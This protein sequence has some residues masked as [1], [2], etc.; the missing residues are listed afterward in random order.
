[1]TAPGRPRLAAFGVDYLLILLYMGLLAASSFIVAP[2][3]AHLDTPW[4]TQ[5]LGFMT[6][7]LPVTLYFAVSEGVVGATLGKRVF[8]LV[9]TD[10]SGAPLPLE[11]SLARSAVK[12]VPW[13][14]GHTA[15]HRLVF[16]TAEGEPLPSW[17]VGFLGI[18]YAL[19]LLLAAWFTFSLF[20]GE[21]RTFYDRI[22]GSR[23]QTRVSSRRFA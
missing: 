6:L 16:W 19:S 17:Q 1:V 18:F 9:V 5:L 7:T 8:G 21:R 4:Q 23:V 10:L 3:L 12:F 13:E 2:T 22:A 14:L 20:L 15:V 11:R